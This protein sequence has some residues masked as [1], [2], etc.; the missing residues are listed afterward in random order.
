[1]MWRVNPHRQKQHRRVA[2]CQIYQLVFANDLYYSNFYFS[3][4]DLL[5][6]VETTCSRPVDSFGNQPAT[7]PLI[8][9]KRL[10]VN[11]LS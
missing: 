10:V 9:C 8:T 2:I 7:S 11:K 3:F 1:M 6:H 4:V 5:Q